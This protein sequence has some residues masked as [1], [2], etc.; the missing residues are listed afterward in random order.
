MFY[1]NNL[2]CFS[3]NYSLTRVSLFV[4]LL[5]SPLSTST[6]STRPL[7][8][9]LSLYRRQQ[10]QQSWWI[11]TMSD[12]RQQSTSTYLSL[13]LSIVWFYCIYCFGY[14][15]SNPLCLFVIPDS[16]LST[17]TTSTRPLSTCH[18][19]VLSSCNRNTTATAMSFSLSTTGTRSNNGNGSGNRDTQTTTQ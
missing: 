5:G 11:Q 8:T 2:L 14:S 15:L 12:A 17:S 7:S 18:H 3:Y 6:M 19:E 10:Q 13:Y 4:S 9:S 16:P 1:S